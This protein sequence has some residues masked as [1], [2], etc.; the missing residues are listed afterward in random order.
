MINIKQSYININL[1]LSLSRKNNESLSENKNAKL[2]NLD[3]Y[4]P[5]HG[6]MK[7]IMVKFKIYIIHYAML[8]LCLCKGQSI[9]II[10]IVPWK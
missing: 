3:L 2:V 6:P 7:K 5:T 9:E 10:S 1:I 4:F 8:L